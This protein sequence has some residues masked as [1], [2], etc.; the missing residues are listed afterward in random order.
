MLG[1]AYIKTW[2]RFQFISA[3]SELYALV[4]GS[5]EALGARCAV[6]HSRR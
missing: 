4:E 2:A 5:K 1:K 3:E 6:G